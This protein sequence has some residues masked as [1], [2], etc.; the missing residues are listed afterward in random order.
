MR[1]KETEK[2]GKSCYYIQKET[3]ATS[4]PIKRRPISLVIRVIREMLEMK[5][6]T[7]L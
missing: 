7:I 1:N 2:K 3:Q 4:E 5:I 6:K